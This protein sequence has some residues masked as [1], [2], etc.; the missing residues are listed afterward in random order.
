MTEGKGKE[1]QT[2]GRKERKEMKGRRKEGKNNVV[3]AAD[4]ALC[5]L[6]G[7]HAVTITQ[8]RTKNIEVLPGMFECMPSGQQVAQTGVVSPLSSPHI[9]IGHSEQSRVLA[10]PTRS[11]CV[12]FC[13]R[14]KILVQKL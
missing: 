7:S 11:R 5:P 1:K 4:K 3:G 9:P 2:D 12:P 6:K 14:H 13:C 10:P 8:K